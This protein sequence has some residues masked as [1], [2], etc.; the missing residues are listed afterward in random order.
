MDGIQAFHQQAELLLCDLGSFRRRSGPA[1]GT[2]L[3]P[4]VQ[5]KEP[6]AAPEQAFAAVRTP[7]AEEEQCSCF[8]GIQFV[9]VSHNLG[10]AIDALPEIHVI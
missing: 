8:K 4:P 9:P 2:V 5:E 7:S 1:H 6:V 3:K 10:Q